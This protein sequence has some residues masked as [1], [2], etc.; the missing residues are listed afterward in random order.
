MLDLFN[1]NEVGIGSF[2]RT[3]FDYFASSKEEFRL[4]FSLIVIG[5]ETTMTIYRNS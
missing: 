3:Y 1:F 2:K 5:D 4:S